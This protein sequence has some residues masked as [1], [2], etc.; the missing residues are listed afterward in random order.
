MTTATQL[1]D[2]ARVSPGEVASRAKEGAV[3][4]V[5]VRTVS[6][7]RAGHIAGSLNVPMDEIESRLEDIPTEK[8]VVVVCQSGQRSEMVRGRLHG[9]LRELVCLEGGM[10]AWEGQGLPVVR[11]VRTRMALDR[12]SM[13][14]ASSLVLLSV[15]LGALVAPTW[16]FLALVPGIGLMLAGT[17]GFCLMGV[18]LSAMPWN[19]VRS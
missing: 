4:V 8:P 3:A 14:G 15:A 2:T 9:R 10:T 6:E 11:S 13:I 1:M 18:I 17:T 19:K 12:Q 16:Y 7:Y 5:D